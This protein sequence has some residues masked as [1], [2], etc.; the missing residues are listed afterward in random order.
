M[1]ME[2]RQFVDYESQASR[3]CVYQ[4]LFVPGLLQTD[5]YARAIAARVIRRSA[6]DESVNAR[7]EI[8]MGRQRDVFARMNGAS[9]LNLVMVLDEAVLL[10]P[11]GGNAVMIRQLDR[12]IEAAAL[13]SVELVV[14][15]LHLDGHPGLGGTFELLEF[16]NAEIP[17]VL[18]VESAACD[19][20]VTNPEITRAYRENL[21][22]L[23]TRGRTGDDAVAAIRDVRRSL[24]D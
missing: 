24:G 4:A 9:A 17:A 5:D 14:V 7:V 22:A 2:Y 12:L 1:S 20:V 10:R 16:P 13:P 15:P 8:R 21:D 11:V 6:D 19:F 23:R 3:I 18:F